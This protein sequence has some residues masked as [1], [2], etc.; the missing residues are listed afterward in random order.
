MIIH[1]AFA[2]AD[3]IWRQTLEVAAGTTVGEALSKSRF[4]QEFAEYTDHWPSIGVF[5]ERCDVARILQPGDRIELC[6]PLVFDPTESRRRRATH[7]RGF[8]AAE[9]HPE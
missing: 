4:R 3:R 1:V 8:P 7:R 9:G 5:G 2:A 6:R